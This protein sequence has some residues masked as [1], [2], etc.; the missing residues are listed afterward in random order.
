LTG[1]LE[2]S[3]EGASRIAILGVGSD[4]RADDAA[5]LLVA[6]KVE[7]ACGDNPALLVVQGATAPENFTGP[8]I[9]FRPSHLVIV[10]C[11]ELGSPPGS[12]RLFPSESIGGVSSNTHSLPLKIVIDYIS[13]SHPCRSVVVGIQPKSLAFDGQPSDEVLRAVD[14]VA[15]ALVAAAGSLRR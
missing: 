2:D 15:E 7:S 4:L 1:L 12:V 9:A 3:L 11:A 5:G 13:L 8:I 6:A 14:R 10:D